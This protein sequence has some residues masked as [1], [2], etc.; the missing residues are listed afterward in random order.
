MSRGIAA[1]KKNNALGNEKECHIKKKKKKK[2]MSTNWKLVEGSSWQEKI[3]TPRTTHSL[4]KYIM[5][6]NYYKLLLELF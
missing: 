4:R 3:L 2:K 5:N 6:W 1:W